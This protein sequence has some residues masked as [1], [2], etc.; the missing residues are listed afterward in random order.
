ML[1]FTDFRRIV[2]FPGT[3]EQVCN[4]SCYGPQRYTLPNGSKV[5]MSQGGIITSPDWY[6]HIDYKERHADQLYRS[7]QQPPIPDGPAMPV[8]WTPPV[9]M[10]TRRQVRWMN[11]PAYM[12]LHP[13][14]FISAWTG[15]NV[16]QLPG[17]PDNEFLG[18]FGG[19]VSDPNCCTEWSATANLYG[20][21]VSPFPYFQ[22]FMMRS[23]N[24]IDEWEIVENL[25]NKKWGN[26]IEDARFL[27]MTPTPADYNLP[28]AG[29][30]GF[31]GVDKCSIGV[32]HT[33]GLW[34]G[35]AD[36]WSSWGPKTLIWRCDI[37]ERVFT[38]P[39][40]WVEGGWWSCDRG[41]LPAFV[42][43]NLAVPVA[44][45]IWTG[46]AFDCPAGTITLAPPNHPGK[47]MT[48]LNKSLPGEVPHRRAHVSFS[49]D[50]VNWTPAQPLT[51]LLDRE[52]GNPQVYAEDDGSI[53]VLLD[54]TECPGAVWGGRGVYE[55]NV[56]L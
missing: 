11:D 32:L 24:G 26:V 34:Y 14:A 5:I 30:T 50:C 10:V 38:Q 53:T 51:E 47:Y 46:N 31:K 54:A 2:S 27:G 4:T 3:P 19:C 21:C 15:G 28:P 36:F 43:N 44:D 13:E 33:D 55:G 37:E 1:K 40:I 48:A 25:F 18:I 41:E 49:N 12:S 39:Q 9:E 35:T 42:N 17:H 56:K 6:L 52:I 29:P 7:A 22:A 16:I 23:P 20:S 8:T 45:R